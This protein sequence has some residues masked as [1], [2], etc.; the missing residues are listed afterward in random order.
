M[1]PPSLAPSPE[2]VDYSSVADLLDMDEADLE[3]SPY[4]ESDETKEDDLV[5]WH[6]YNA[7]CRRAD[8]LQSYAV[9]GSGASA[10]HN[11]TV[12]MH[13][14]EAL[15]F[16]EVITDGSHPVGFFEVYARLYGVRLFRPIELQRGIVRVRK[17]RSGMSTIAWGETVSFS[18]FRRCPRSRL[19]W[20]SV[21]YTTALL[22]YNG[23]ISNIASALTSVSL[24]S[25]S[26]DTGSPSLPSVGHRQFHMWDLLYNLSSMV[27]LQYLWLVCRGASLIRSIALRMCSR[28][29]TLIS[30][31]RATCRGVADVSMSLGSDS[32]WLLRWAFYA[33]AGV[34][35]AWSTL[36]AGALLFITGALNATA[37]VLGAA[38]EGV[39]SARIDSLDSLEFVHFLHNAI[40]S[41]CC[42]SPVSPELLRTHVHASHTC[43]PH[44][45]STVF[46]C[47]IV[48]WS[49]TTSLA[50]PL[51]VGRK[52]VSSKLVVCAS[53]DI[54]GPPS[55][56]VGMEI[57]AYLL[58]VRLRTL[59]LEYDKRV[60]FS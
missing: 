20:P 57:F 2:W 27:S 33:I 11:L 3:R 52:L 10:L 39:E 42:V 12:R 28:R 60:A 59:I 44:I 40:F 15:Y 24:E 14:A 16:Q 29:I 54:G 21:P 1:R 34:L 50:S 46:A 32:T 18:R 9:L 43:S 23:S 49:L 17:P 53:L 5:S 58:M 13:R 48:F 26:E 7:R 35:T 56:S 19:P 4:I 37:H 6:R 38:L 45:G 30:L 47:I 41:P 31:L 25:P 51:L 8:Q 22:Q 55:P 36:T